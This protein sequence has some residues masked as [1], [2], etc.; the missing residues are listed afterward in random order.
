MNIALWNPEYER[1]F[2]VLFDSSYC[3]VGF[4]NNTWVSIAQNKINMQAFF[5]FPHL[6]YS[7]KNPYSIDDLQL[8]V[9]NTQLFSLVLKKAE[10]E[11]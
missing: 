6:K 2:Q 7:Q 3:H 5:S 11:R 4:V 9:Y 1:R 8:R 10:T